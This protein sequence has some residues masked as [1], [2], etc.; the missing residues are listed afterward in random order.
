MTEQKLITE[1]AFA[2]VILSSVIQESEQMQERILEQYPDAKEKQIEKAVGIVQQAL[3]RRSG[4]SRI[5][6]VRER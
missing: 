3:L 4:Y 2:A 5:G 1:E 6:F